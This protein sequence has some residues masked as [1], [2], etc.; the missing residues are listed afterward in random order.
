[1]KISHNI[2]ADRASGAQMIERTLDRIGVL[3]LLVLGVTT[4]GATVLVGV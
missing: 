2:T 4:A 3:F 1:M